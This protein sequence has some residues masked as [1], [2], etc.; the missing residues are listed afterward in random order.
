MFKSF[1]ARPAAP[2]AG[3][4]AK[5][6]P[7]PRPA[8]PT[9]EKAAIEV[10]E[11]GD[12]ITISDVKP[13]ESVSLM[14]DAEGNVTEATVVAAD[15]TSETIALPEPGGRVESASSTLEPAADTQPTTTP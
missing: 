14:A 11:A 9:N 3:F 2:G 8:Q 5:F 13:D 15:G 10:N 7:P 4:R 1:G 12:G 6:A